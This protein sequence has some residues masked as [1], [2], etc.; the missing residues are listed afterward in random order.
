MKPKC[1][2]DFKKAHKRVKGKLKW[3]Q[4]NYHSA[5]K[6][7]IKPF[8]LEE[9]FGVAILQRQHRLITQQLEMKRLANVKQGGEQSDEK[10]LD[11]NNA[12]LEEYLTKLQ[13]IYWKHQGNLSRYCYMQ[14]VGVPTVKE[15]VILRTHRDRHG[16][17]Y[18]WVLDQERCAARGWMLR[19]SLSLL[20]EGA[21]SVSPT[22]QRGWAEG[23]S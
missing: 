6:G 11:Y 22:C 7:W 21:G 23:I 9:Q 3:K 18:S 15:Q 12:V 19:A 10:I 2:R 17:L 8:Q 13:E 4:A 16:R 5:R 14:P 20:R 1:E